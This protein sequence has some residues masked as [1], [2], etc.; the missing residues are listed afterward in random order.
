M[1]SENFQDGHHGGHLDYWYGM[2]LAV[3]NLHVTLMPPNKFQLNLTWFG[4]RCCLKNF[5]MT[6]MV[7]IFDSGTERF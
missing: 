2:L 7:A 3:L 6:T 4:R 1:S 5:K